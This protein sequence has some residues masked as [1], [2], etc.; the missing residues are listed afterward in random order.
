LK[1]VVKGHFAHDLLV[2]AVEEGVCPVGMEEVV[3]DAVKSV[4]VKTWR[5]IWLEPVFSYLV[6]G[7]ILI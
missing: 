2:F 5:V 6:Y 7:R 4:R 1:A 3:S